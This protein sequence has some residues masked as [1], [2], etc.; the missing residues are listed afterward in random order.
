MKQKEEYSP[1]VVG[2][3]ILFLA[4]FIALPPL[5]R[6]LYPEEVVEDEQVN[7]SQILNCERI[8]IKNN[9]KIL[10][11]ITY[12]NG[13]PLRNNISFEEY[14]PSD[15]DKAV[16]KP[17][18]FGAAE[19]LTLFQGVMKE[20]ITQNGTTY[21]LTITNDIVKSADPNSGITDYFK[22]GAGEQQAFLE[23]LGATCTMIDL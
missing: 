17:D 11:R 3:A 9:Y 8:S 19:E 13:A 2:A 5:F 21:S 1:L 4:M 14:A 7:T 22:G 23:G 16:A 20:Q 10:Y 15:A 12:E 18:E 6:V